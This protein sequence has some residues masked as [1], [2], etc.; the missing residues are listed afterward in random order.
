MNAHT[1]PKSLVEIAPGDRWVVLVMAGTQGQA[2]KAA[3]HG[4]AW[5]PMRLCPQRQAADPD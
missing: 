2:D 4:P 5:S 3:A 1:I